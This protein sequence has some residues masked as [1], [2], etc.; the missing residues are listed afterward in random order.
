MKK[1]VIVLLLVF[2]LYSCGEME[3]LP[4]GKKYD[5]GTSVFELADESRSESYTEDPSDKRKIQV[6][7][8]YPAKPD[9]EG[10]PAFYNS[11]GVARQF[12]KFFGIPS[13]LMEGGKG[14]ALIDIEPEKEGFPVLIFNHGWT[15]WEGQN[16]ASME[17]FASNG[18]IVL[19]INHPYET[20]H[21]DFLDGSEASYNDPVYL[22]QMKVMNKN[23]DKT[24]STMSALYQPVLQAENESQFREAM[25]NLAKSETYSLITDSIGRQTDDT[26]F[27]INSLERLNSDVSFLLYGILQTDNIGIL[28][29][30]F[31][32]IVC[33]ELS[34]RGMTQV[35]A[36]I[37][38]DSPQIFTEIDKDLSLK[39]PYM[40]ISST[41][42]NYG[43]H[44]LDLSG[45]NDIY[46]ELTEKSVY[47]ASISG[48]AHFN[49]SDMSYIGFLK[50]TPMLGSIDNLRALEIIDRVTL[51]YFDYYLKG[52]QKPFAGWE[53]EI[54]EWI[55]S[56]KN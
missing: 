13:F 25:V 52:G 36:G 28:G 11:K 42:V 9:Q 14:R 46:T 53:A 31:G 55:V 23:A 15:S 21:T 18:Y 26:E 34:I 47:N 35:K 39:N 6:R 16:A 20:L 45:I 32:G 33:G 22:E 2:L 10:E 44:E 51:E 7:V 41:E 29:H 37:S 17:R 12:Q 19:A 3:L 8:W 54:P 40:F 30:S 4:L 43:K 49:F 38:Y 48:T 56:A 27:L 5:V 24:G 1:I 50:K